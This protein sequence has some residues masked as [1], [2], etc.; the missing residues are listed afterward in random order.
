MGLAW[1]FSLVN[2][3]CSQGDRAEADGIHAKQKRRYYSCLIDDSCKYCDKTKDLRREPRLRV[4][5]P[6]FPILGDGKG[7]N[8]NTGVHFSRGS[9]IQCIDANQGGYFEQMLLLPCALGEFRQE[10]KRP[11]LNP[12]IVGFAEHITSDIGS[13]GDFAAGAETAM[14]TVLQRCYYF[15]GGRMHY[16]H[17]DMMNKDGEDKRDEGRE[18]RQGKFA[19]SSPL[20]QPLQDIFAGMDFT[21]RGNGRNIVHREDL[22]FNTILIFFAKLSAGTGE[23]L[24]TRQVLRLGHELDLPEFLTFYYAHG[25]FYVTQFLLSKS[26]PLLVFIWLVAVFD[27]AEQNFGAL[28]PDQDAD[29]KSGAAVMATFL[30]TQFSRLLLLFIAAQMAP[31]FMQAWLESSAVSAVL[32]MGKQ[33]ITLAP[34]HFIFQAKVIGAYI[35]NEVTLGGAKYM[36]TGRGLPTQR[37]TFLR[38]IDKGWAW[39]A[40]ARW[41]LALGLTICSWL[42]APFIFNP[43]QFDR[44]DFETDLGYW[45][46]FFFDEKG[47]H[48]VHWYTEDRIRPNAGLRSSIVEVLK[49]AIF[50]GCWYTIL[51]QKA[52]R[53]GPEI[54]NFEERNK[55]H[56][57]GG[58]ELHPP[59]AQ[60]LLA[61]GPAPEHNAK[62]ETP[63]APGWSALLVVV[64]DIVETV[65]YMYKLIYVKWWKSLAVGLLLKFCLISVC[66]ELCECACRLKFKP[67][68]WLRLPVKMWLRGHRMAQDIFVSC[69]ILA[70][71]SLGVMLCGCKNCACH[72]LLIYRDTG[73]AQ[74]KKDSGPQGAAPQGGA[75]SAPQVVHPQPSAVAGP[76]PS[77]GQGVE[78]R[79]TGEG[80]GKLPSASGDPAGV[81]GTWRG[82]LIQELKIL[83]DRQ[84]HRELNTPMDRQVHQEVK[85]PRD[86]QVHREAKIRWQFQRRKKRRKTKEAEEAELNLRSYTRSQVQ[87]QARSH[88]QV[89]ELS[90]GLQVKAKESCQA[91]REIPQELQARGVV[92]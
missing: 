77:A 2:E 55:R 14:G 42:F 40:R 28:T 66:L 73:G 70:V 67:P 86:R 79:P 85:S 7:D 65:L 53:A 63:V 18:A 51:N 6:G 36:P 81:A 35:T 87:S 27:D 68:K 56:A 76:Q 11:G 33:I 3:P 15:L 26:I 12:R 5:L 39:H 38:R 49:K 1:S 22:G 62:E 25:G 50:L 41:L 29:K 47:K 80:Q 24:L 92:I 58:L 17:P 54:L 69:L 82:D 44:K 19:S 83:T 45:K 57:D 61:P 16:G 71:L 13:L 59:S 64:L 8:Q 46:E 31:L 88:R 9:I 60:H 21:L 10:N 91:H 34:L 20:A 48:W 37:R 75:P 23:Q 90:C 43:Y 4:E 74:I 84:V 72:N 32:R 89:K 52:A 30:A 78:L